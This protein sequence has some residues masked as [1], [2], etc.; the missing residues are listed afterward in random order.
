MSRYL[1]TFES[2]LGHYVI[3]ILT[4]YTHPIFITYLLDMLE[5]VL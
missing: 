5:G 3:S 1:G 2:M 4:Y